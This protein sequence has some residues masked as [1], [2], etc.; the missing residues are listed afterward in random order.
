MPTALQRGF[1]NPVFDAQA[2]FKA[3]MWALSRPGLSRPVRGAD[4]APAPLTP[5]LGALALTLADFETSVW[6]DAALA[7]APAVERWLKFHTGTKLAATPVEAGFALIADG[8]AMPELAAFGLGT[9]AY[10]DQSTTL[11]IAV[12]GFGAGTAF[13]F[14][15]PGVDGALELRIEGLPAAVLAGWA[16][17]KAAFPRGVDVILAGPDSVIGLPRTVS[18]TVLED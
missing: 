1:D 11:L 17:N 10:P 8:A 16:D 9:Q 4:A 2:V 18:I 7:A 13:R 15:G 3:A 6:L 5:V 12:A 14:E